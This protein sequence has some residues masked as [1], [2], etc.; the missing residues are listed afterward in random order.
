MQMPSHLASDLLATALYGGNSLLLVQ[1]SGGN[2]SVKSNSQDQLWIKA[3][4][5]RLADVS[6]RQ[7]IASLRLSTLRELVARDS[8]KSKPNNLDDRR[9]R[10]EDAVQ[11]IQAAMLNPGQGR[12]SLETGFHSLL[13]D[14]VLHLHPVYLNA[15]TCMDGGRELLADI[16]PQEF[17]WVSYAAPGQELAIQINHALKTQPTEECTCFVLENHGFIASGQNAKQVIA[18]T[19]QFL[20]VAQTFFGDFSP[21]LLVALPAKKASQQ[22]ADKLRSLHRE[23]WGEQSVVIRPARFGV[24]NQLDNQPQLF[25]SPGALVPDD[26]VYGGG[27][28]Q[29][30]S[31]KGLSKWISNMPDAPP[32]K[33]AVAI[34]GMGTVLLARSEGLAAAMEEM[35]LAHILV[36]M[37][38][39]RR[40]SV[41]TLPQH[42]VEYL[43]SMESEKYRVMLRAKGA[44]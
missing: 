24:F 12:A 38:I 25:E 5:T 13:G 42:E 21:D 29:R 6:T 2:N 39:A 30:C 44:S 10:H 16:A 32:E 37:L 36:R 40:G 26:V 27:E 1:A 19:E 41:R 11:Q 33:L 35:L 7:G 15:F 8:A 14:V 18:A 23:R 17:A 34:E 22:A 31:L 20:N 28:I 43:Q 4:G 9:S 3:S